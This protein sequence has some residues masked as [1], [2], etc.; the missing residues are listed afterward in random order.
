MTQSR[1]T[2]DA[3]QRSVTRIRFIVSRVLPLASQFYGCK[4]HLLQTA[5]HT[6]HLAFSAYPALLQE[7]CT[8]CHI[9]ADCRTVLYIA[10]RKVKK[11]KFRP[12]TGDEGPEGEYMYSCTL[13]LTWALDRGGWLAPR[14]GLFYPR[15]RRPVHIV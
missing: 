1:C 5:V 10:L 6:I 12:R 2:N 15:E 3:L 7:L 4:S 14:P 13:S 11:S 9:H 8:N